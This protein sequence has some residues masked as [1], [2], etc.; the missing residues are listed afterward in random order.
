MNFLLADHHLGFWG[1]QNIK[2][3]TIMKGF[4]SQLNL[5]ENKMDCDQNISP[6]LVT[7]SEMLREI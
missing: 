7:E 5:E 2:A 6:A 3:D 1:I 4:E